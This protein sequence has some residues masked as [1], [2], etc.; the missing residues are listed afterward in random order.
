MHTYNYLLSV[1]CKLLT[2]SFCFDFFCRSTTADVSATVCGV[3]EEGRGGEGGGGE[4]DG[5]APAGVFMRSGGST[6]TVGNS[7]DKSV[8]PVQTIV[9][10]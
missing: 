4:V 7:P 2:H 8:G 3:G 5:G 1:V 10:N 6:V 9:Q